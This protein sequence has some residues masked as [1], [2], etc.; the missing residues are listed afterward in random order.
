VAAQEQELTGEQ[1]ELVAIGASVGAGC[2]PCVDHHL[3]AGTRAGLST[4][5]LLAGVINAELAAAESAERLTEHV[6]VELGSEV[7]E[8]RMVAAL[9]EALACLGGALGSN[10]L[11]NVKHQLLV[12]RQLGMSQPQL[13]EAIELGRGVQEN[14]TRMHY[15][16]ALDLLTHATTTDRRTEDVTSEEEQVSGETNAG[17]P[18][19]VSMMARLLALMDSCDSDGLTEKMAECFSVFEA[20]CCQP[21]LMAPRGEPSGSTSASPS[22]TTACDCSYKCP[23]SSH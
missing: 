6:R 14:A 15:R 13:R 21:G 18:D 7:K 3:K 11:T 17:A 8:P 12:C 23:P 22:S 20:G 16:A 19:F 10:D 1:K 4:E 5:R 9:D 2:H